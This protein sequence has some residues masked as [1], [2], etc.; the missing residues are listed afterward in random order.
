MAVSNTIALLP[1][2]LFT[3]LIIVYLLLWLVYLVG[4]SEAVKVGEHIVRRSVLSL[5]LKS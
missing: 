2:F 1:V 5:G 4:T 3:S